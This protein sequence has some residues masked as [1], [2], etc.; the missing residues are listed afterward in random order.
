M[1]T[2]LFR[3]DAT[4]DIGLAEQIA[5]NVRGALM[6]GSLQPGAQLPP[7]RQVATGLDVN[8]HTVLRGYQMLRDENILELRRGRGATIRADIDL[9][10]LT[11]DEKISALATAAL[12]VGWT[13]QQTANALTRAMYRKTGTTPAS[14]T[15]DPATRAPQRDPKED[16]S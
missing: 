3:I 12:A 16:V 11:L 7:A 8:M 1:Q 6:A 2:M 15:A 14:S 9:A 13:P 4:S 10:D 5:A